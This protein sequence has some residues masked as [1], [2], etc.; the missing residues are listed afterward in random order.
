ML[1]SSLRFIPS[2]VGSILLCAGILL[3]GG[4]DGAGSKR[5]SLYQ[6]LSNEGDGPWRIEQLNGPLTPELGDRK[7]QVAFR[8]GDGRT[9]RM[10]EGLSEDSTVVIAAG[11]VALPGGENLQMLGG[12]G[13]FG[14]VAWT[15]RF[16]ASR[17]VFTLQAGSRAFLQALFPEMGW[18]EG[19]DVEMTLAPADE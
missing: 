4:C 9:Y 3:L 2:V 8:Q 7:I 5:A 19:L 15:Y 10:V 14:S 12:F 13:Q 6:R 1:S 16:Q 17:A 18:S 11:A